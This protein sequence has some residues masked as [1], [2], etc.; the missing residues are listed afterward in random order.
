MS[1][2][3]AF[4][5]AAEP[6]AS[7]DLRRV[8]AHPDHWYPLAWSR[9]VRRGMTFAARFAGQ[10]IV[11]VR[12]ESGG[13]FAL[14]DR[15]A[16]RQVPLHA[17]VVSGEQLKC[18]Y[19]G[20][21][22]DRHGRCV[23]VPYIG[24]DRHPNGVRAYPVRELAGLVF[25]FPGDAALADARPL[26]DLSRVLD[27]R[28]KTRRI[29]RRIA[30]HYTFMHEN[31]MDMNNQFLHRRRMGGLRVMCLGHRS[32]GDTFEARYTF[33]RTHGR[34]P[35]AE[36]AIFSARKRDV[37]E[38]QNLMTIRTVY[39]HQTLSFRFGPDEPVMELFITYVPQDA[40]QRTIRTFGTISVRRPRIPGLIQLG[41][42]FLVWFTE[43]IFR[44][45]H[46]IVER[47]Q[48]AWDEQAR[49]AN[50]EIFPAIRDLRRFL[51]A[52]GTPQKN[53]TP[54]DSPHPPAPSA[55]HAVLHRPW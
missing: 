36:S 27:P 35:L 52:H 49:D 25:V 3:T 32:A 38:D 1:H 47:E 2:A 31:L 20:W 19:H 16:H 34:R 7:I 9:E 10:P 14:E 18:C 6:G 50:Q 42:P 24:A 41:W 45:D 43:A 15:C 22:Y 51:A 46:W 26:P 30:C 55:S 44:E 40:G 39:P 54:S 37:G 29:G 53:T 48:E 23:S 33:L 8:G 12:A 21:T 17:G 5:T 28:F 13:V 11:L 4:T